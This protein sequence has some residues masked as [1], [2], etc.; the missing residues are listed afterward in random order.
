MH[1]K[2]ERV[3]MFNGWV[4]SNRTLLIAYSKMHDND[5]PNRQITTVA[6]SVGISATSPFSQH[7]G[8]STCK[9]RHTQP[10]RF[11]KCSEAPIHW[12]QAHNL[13][14][15]YLSRK[16]NMAIFSVHFRWQRRP[17]SIRIGASVTP[18]LNAGL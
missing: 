6:S 9:C 17:P 8:S 7:V 12:F 4:I 14:D 18:L 13:F 3:I 1:P 2:R 10:Q 16:T 15:I 11:H 5:K